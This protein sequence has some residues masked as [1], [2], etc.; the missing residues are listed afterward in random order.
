MEYNIV[1]IHMHV[2]MQTFTF[3]ATPSSLSK[4]NM[5]LK[6]QTIVHVH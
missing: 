1:Q 6:M 5:Q 3:V 4:E 2:L